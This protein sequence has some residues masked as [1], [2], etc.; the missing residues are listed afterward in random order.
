MMLRKMVEEHDYEGALTII[1]ESDE[2]AKD[3][4]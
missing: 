2:V 1:S 4:K 3:N